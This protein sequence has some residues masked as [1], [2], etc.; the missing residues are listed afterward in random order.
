MSATDLLAATSPS[1]G[2]FAVRVHIDSAQLAP[3]R[4]RLDAVDTKPAE[5]AEQITARLVAHGQPPVSPRRQISL[6][7][8][9]VV[10][11]ITLL[12]LATCCNLTFTKRKMKS[13][14]DRLMEAVTENEPVIK[15]V[16]ARGY[17][18]V[19]YGDHGPYVEMRPE[20]V[21]PLMCAGGARFSKAAA[22]SSPPE[23]A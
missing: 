16:I 9:I 13:Q 14:Q 5:T 19:I 22:R 20:H 7:R 23:K 4:R 12:L 1:D 11:A 15:A 3:S 17:E 10:P 2:H 21:A 8:Y 6:I 18:R